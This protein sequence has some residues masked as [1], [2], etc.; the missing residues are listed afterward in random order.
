[1]SS[2]GVNPDK[3]LELIQKTYHLQATNNNIE[4]PVQNRS[5]IAKV[6]HHQPSRKTS[7]HDVHEA[8]REDLNKVMFL[9]EIRTII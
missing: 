8:T 2:T 3:P 9:D 5:S 4:H 6:T 1:M 7:V